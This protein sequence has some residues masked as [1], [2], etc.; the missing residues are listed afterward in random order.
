MSPL[1]FLAF[2]SLLHN[3][4]IFALMVMA[5]IFGLGMQIPNSA[6]LDGYTKEL[7]EESL[8]AGLGHI[9]IKPVQGEY[10]TKAN[11]IGKAVMSHHWARGYASRL[12]VPGVLVKQQVYQGIRVI[13]I[14][15]SQEENTFRLS[16]KFSDGALL[17]DDERDAVI[18]GT[19]VAEWASVRPGEKVLLYIL[20]GRTPKPFRLTVKGILDAGFISAKDVFVNKKLLEWDLKIED[21]ASSIVVATDNYRKAALYR[22]ELKDSISDTAVVTWREESDFVANAISGNETIRTI[23]EIMVIIGITIP[24]MALLYI[25]VLHKRREIGIIAAIGFS[26]RDIFVIFFLR[27]LF[28]A[29]IGIAGGQVLGL[30]ISKYFQMRPMFE[31]SGFIIKPSISFSTITIPTLIIFITTMLSGVYPAII[32]SRYN[33]AKILREG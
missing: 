20:T 12:M 24:V 23:S 19:K 29:F 3:K 5:V 18:I 22:N 27:S 8:N 15:P 10:L 14:V 16:Q 17:A 4:L 28:I 1:I 21:I 25:S 6:N 2:K 30:L 13:G 9:I 7:V 33:L 31:W 32:A 26:K 11:D